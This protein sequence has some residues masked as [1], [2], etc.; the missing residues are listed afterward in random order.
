MTARRTARVLSS[1]FVR[2]ALL[3]LLALSVQAQEARAFRARLSPTP[4]DVSMQSRIAGSG[5]VT[6]TLDKTTLTITGT[7]EGLRSP[8]SV[9]RLHRGYRGIRGPAFADLKVTSATNGTLSGS[10]ELT[11]SQVSDLRKS[12][13]YIQ[14]HSEKAPEGNLWGWLLPAR[15]PKK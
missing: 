15:E 3:L 6:A 10:I 7:F 8:A 12:L 4:L 13:F 2:S 11:P 14:L 1:F 5:S 9:A